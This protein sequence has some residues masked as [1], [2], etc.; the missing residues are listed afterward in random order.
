MNNLK[1][2]TSDALTRTASTQ[3]IWLG[4]AAT[5]G[6]AM[7]MGLLYWVSSLTGSHTTT[8]NA[9]DAES[10]TVT[11][12]LRTEPP[13]LDSTRATD[14][15]SISVLGHVM[16]GLLRFDENNQLAPGVAER[17]EIR[18]DGA[19]FWLRPDARWS[20]GVPVTAHD[21][22]FAWRTAISPATASEY[23]FILYPVKNGESINSGNLPVEALGVRAVNNQT[24]EVEFEQPLAY[25]EE[26]VAFSTY[27]P[28]REDFYHSREGRYG[29][30]VDDLLYNGPFEMTLWVHGAH[31]RLEK[32]PD[33]W[34]RERIRL[35]VIDMPY[36]TTD[37]TSALNLFKD[38]KVAVVDY[39][40]AEQLNEV[41]QQRWQLKRFGDGSVWFLAFNFSPDR[42]TSNWHLRKALQLVTDPSELVNRVIKLP[43]NL[44]G[45][46]LFPVWLQ[47][48]N[49][50]FR[51][52]HP[53]PK[54]ELNLEA[55]REHL[56]IAMEELGLDNPP[57]IALLVDDSP[58]AAKQAEYFQNLYGS[59]LGLDIR[60][61]RQI[62][63][64]RLAKMQNQDFDLAVYGWGPDFA[65]PLT[66]GELFASWNPNNNGRFNNTEY[67]ESVRLAQSSLN[68]QTRM[69]AF[70]RQQEILIEEVALI[71]NY[72]R[73][74][75]Y[76]TDR[77]L[78]GVVRRAV[79]PDPD[80]TNAFISSD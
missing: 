26:L 33:Y 27:H 79:G 62:F 11:L 14:S 59:Q 75:V 50:F 30:D 12:L 51:Q 61:D 20:D 70:A 57:S 15:V 40:G 41:L 22:V 34:G 28:I 16:E 10:G 60:I 55:A 19:T 43:G 39:L 31:V 76:I 65:D 72:E 6:F 68:P 3:L 74:R 80:Y 7:L 17:W 5:I 47:G 21:F 48:V 71:P 2:G 42:I 13:Q 58:G 69:E 25:F 56:E 53:V 49:T 66:F 77:R 29:A 9:I 64:Q 38:G 1:S 4:L 44:P 46:S 63:K 78:Q 32:N 54:I 45:E 67:D 23:A 35:N 18:E 73:G 24:L 52:E 8:L 37:A 36:F